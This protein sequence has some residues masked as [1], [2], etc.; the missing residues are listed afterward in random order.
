MDMLEQERKRLEAYRPPLTKQDDFPDF[1]ED[2]LRQAAKVSLRPERKG[3][4]YPSPYVSVEEISYCGFDETRIHGILLLPRFT[5]QK[6][7]ACL[8]HFHG[9][10][11]NC[12]MPAD[13]MAWVT[14]GM[15]VLSVDCRMQGG[16]TGNE[17]RYSSG[18]TGNVTTLGILDPAEYYY[19]AVYMDC[20]KAL[21]F[22]AGCEEIDSSRLIVEGASQG[23]ALATAVAALSTLPRLA[24]TD[25]PSNSNLQR[26]VE[27]EHGSFAAVAAYLKEH[28]AHLGRAMETLSYFD[29]MNLAD[30]ITCPVFASVALRDTVC[31]A[32]CYFATYNRILSDKRIEV[33]PFNGHDGAGHVQMQKKLE[34]VYA[35]GI[36]N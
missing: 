24:L 1:W 21:S 16:K 32:E 27:G 36:L 4:A 3:L 8:V 9:F 34:A 20:V 30:R 13:F 33:Y 17:A 14:M 5:E 26:R 18:M 23:G 15:A 10:S 22:A 2:T 31:P 11:G 28:P 29:T 7:H 35:S 19:R 25:V 6:R 12:G